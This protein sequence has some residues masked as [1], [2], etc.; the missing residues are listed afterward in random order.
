MKYIWKRDNCRMRT[1]IFEYDKVHLNKANMY[2][3]QGKYC[4][5]KVQYFSCTT[6]EAATKFSNKTTPQSTSFP[7]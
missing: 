6:F 5:N 3:S 2:V 7:I 1:Y 4:Y